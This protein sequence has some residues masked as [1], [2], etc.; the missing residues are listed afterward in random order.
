[1]EYCWVLEPDVEYNV[2]SLN[3]KHDKGYKYLLSTKR[4]FL[5]LLKS[6]LKQ[7]W[8]QKI[9]ENSIEKIDKSF[10]LQDFSGKESDIIYKVKIDGR[11]VFFYILLELQSTV[12]YQMPYR[13]LQYILEI[14]RTILRDT[15][16]KAY[17]RKDFKLP[18]IIP[19]V[20]Y[21]GKYNWT[22][23][24]SFKEMLVANELFGDYILD[25]KYILFDVAR[26]SE[27]ELLNLGNLIG[28]AF[29]VDQKAQYNEV[30]SSLKKLADILK[31]I[32]KEDFI[33]FKNWLKNIAV[34]T[35]P[36]EQAVE[37][38]RI[39][40]ES[41]EA[42]EMEYALGISIYNEIKQAELKGN[43]KGKLEGKI[44]GKLEVAKKMLDAGM[45]IEQVSVF[46]DLP[47]DKIQGF[48]KL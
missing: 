11:E 40:D 46:T 33:L 38:E 5:Q 24:I 28:A 3:N 10:I 39:I 21:N 15:G 22:A 12:D 42:E 2:N 35:L 23:P 1:M 27:K 48:R 34:Y 13:L 7:S 45:K 36:K 31:R 25:F 32:S 44:E 47:V 29:Y 30:L 18:A 41:E 20:L 37:I 26:Y 4:I 14:W 8:V 43:L 9:D 19:C 6:F 17:K 16:E